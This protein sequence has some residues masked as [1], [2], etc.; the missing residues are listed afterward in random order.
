[1]SRFEKVQLVDCPRDA[2][3][4]IEHFIPTAKKIDYINQLAASGLFDYIDFGSFVSPQ[5]VPQLR[6]TEE[7]LAGINKKTSKL[8]AI[9]ANSKGIE[10]ALPF[11]AIDYLGYPFSMSETFQLRNTKM[12]QEAAFQVIEQGKERMAQ[13]GN[14]ELLV[15]LS[16]GFGNP[17]GDTWYPELVL[18]WMERLVQAGIHT[19]S[20]ADTTSEATP[21][22]VESM[23][24]LIHR[25][26]PT[27]ELRIHLHSRI[28]SALLKIE[29]AY[30]GGCRIFEGA[31]MGYG[32]CP[33]AQDDLVGNIPSELLL[34][35]FKQPD[36][37]VVADLLQGF[38]NLIKE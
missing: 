12:N 28:E 1:M 16:M 3:Q 13:A 7:V 31:I 21:E 14:Q 37:K 26:F 24:S 22:Q 38:Q 29:A 20:I 8:I 36:N 5:A 6:D 4:G 33:F 32:G 11:Q 30:A 25:T 15:Y 34:H 19:F 23:F 10:R 2:I 9:V 27:V 18:E 35:E 17:Y